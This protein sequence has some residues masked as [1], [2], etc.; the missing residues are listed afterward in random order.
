[1]LIIPIEQKPDSSRPPVITL[2]LIAVNCLVFFGYQANDGV[3]F[4]QAMQ[5]YR[6][7]ELLTYEAPVYKEYLEQH[8]REA[9]AQYLKLEDEERAYWIVQDI[10]F[11]RYLN[12]RYFLENSGTPLKW[13]DA[14]AE[15]D[16]T[17]GRISY[18]KYG[19]IPAEINAIDMVVS[20]FLH[21]D[22][23]HLFFNMLFLFVYGFSL[24][25]ALGKWWFLGI[26]L[27]SGLAGDLLTWAVGPEVTTPTVGASGAV[28]GLLGMYL[29]LY[30][31]RK[32]RF[33]FT[34][35]FYAHHFKAPALALLPYWGLIELYYQL[36]ATDNVAHFAHIGGLLAGFVVV[37]AARNRLI[38][39]DHEYVN[40]VDTDEPFRRL[41]DGLLRQLESV[42]FAAAR[43]TLDEL[44][45]L[46]PD[47]VRLLKHSFDLWKLKPAN[48]HFETAARS[49][50]SRQQAE[51]LDAH[52][53]QRLLRDYEKLTRSGGALDAQNRIGLFNLFLRMRETPA[54]VEQYDALDKNDET[55]QNKLPGM[56]L[57]LATS[58]A[59]QG[60]KGKADFYLQRLRD[61]FPDSEAAQEAK[62]IRL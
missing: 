50:F 52:V 19:L 1:M 25:V 18:L 21:G 47:D 24:E 49:I 60:Q 29:G 5:V 57:R 22:F 20:M 32:I 8:D 13:M 51:R 2:L 56:L 37:F 39:I 42:D 48:E 46:R 43:K 31:M 23:G 12:K 61:N 17:I 4:E 26:Y 62:A 16:R 54:A 11:S 9:Y 58:F 15:V 55:L 40:K 38:R 41:Y 14:R 45:S 6:E 10:D 44:L 59:S 27:L 7:A 33:F 35:G 30:G 28:F 34:V 36:T 3:Y 53:L